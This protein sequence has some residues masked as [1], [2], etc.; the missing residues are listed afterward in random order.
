[1]S[2][3]RCPVRWPTLERYAPLP[4]PE[5]ASGLI[6]VTPTEVVDGHVLEEVVGHDDVVGR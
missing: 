3:E 2:S 6:G 4:G 1:V 5:E